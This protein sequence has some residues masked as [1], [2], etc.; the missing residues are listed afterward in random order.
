MTTRASWSGLARLALAGGCVA[1]LACSGRSPAR[2]PDEPACTPGDP[3][4][5]P[6]AA[7]DLDSPGAPWLAFA[8]AA[9]GSWDVA[10]ARADGTCRRSIVTDPGQ[11]LYPTWSPAA[12]IAFASDRS[13]SLGIWIHDLAAGTE[14]RFDLGELRATY[15]AWSP[16]GTQLAFEG[17]LPGAAAS[18]IYLVAAEGGT[19][20]PVT[21]GAAVDGAP[22]WAADGS[23]IFFVSNRTGAY[24][25]FS[26]SPAG[27]P[28]SQV[29]HGSRIVGRP[30][31]SPDGAALA[32]AR[33]G[34]GST[35]VVRMSLATGLTEVVTSQGDSE[36]AYAPGAG[37]LAV[38]SYRHGAPEVLL[39]DAVTGDARVRLAPGVSAG[40]PSFQMIR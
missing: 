30:A 1:A 2:D 20:T 5:D 17:S 36:P 24:E 25:V 10:I 14:T 19:P 7:C 4:C 26:V 34:G 9:A 8:T 29:T 13:G 22:A 6:P 11:D 39:L 16:D 23:A 32:W 38:R 3:D 31:P 12:R 27:G 28:T 18:A 15:P 37:G 21:D 40:S 35:E 33:T